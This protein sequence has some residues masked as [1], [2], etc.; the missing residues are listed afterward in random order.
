MENRLLWKH[1]KTERCDEI[2]LWARDNCGNAI[3]YV[4]VVK[5]KF[6]GTKQIFNN[7]KYSEAIVEFLFLGTRKMDV[8]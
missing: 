8:N 3:K 7:V 6:G 1:N 5:F 2:P 4:N